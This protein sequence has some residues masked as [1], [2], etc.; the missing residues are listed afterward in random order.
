MSENDIIAEF[1]KSKYPELI[2]GLDFTF[3]KIGKIAGEAIKELS[4]NLSKVFSSIDIESIK[5]FVND[6]D[7]IYNEAIELEEN[8]DE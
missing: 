8:E 3:Y 1:I 5:D 2:S 4:K 7:R 6:A